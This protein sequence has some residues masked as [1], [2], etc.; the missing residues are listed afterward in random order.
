MSQRRPPVLPGVISGT[1]VEVPKG[2]WYKCGGRVVRLKR[3]RPP[4][5]HHGTT[6]L[7]RPPPP[8]PTSLLLSPFPSSMPHPCGLQLFPPRPSGGPRGKSTAGG[9]SSYY[10]HYHYYYYYYYTPF[11]LTWRI[12]STHFTCTLMLVFGSRLGGGSPIFL[13]SGG[14]KMEQEGSGALGT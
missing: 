1:P 6:S 3:R 5:H 4:L 10:Y 14:W 11:S 8:L 2:K 9:E 13:P 7:L 12:S